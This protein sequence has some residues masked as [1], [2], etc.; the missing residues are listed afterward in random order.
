MEKKSKT[1]RV[2]AGRFRVQR[3]VY[4]TSQKIHMIRIS[5]LRDITKIWKKS[6]ILKMSKVI[7]KLPKKNFSHKWSGDLSF[8]ISNEFIRFSESV[9]IYSVFFKSSKIF[10]KISK[11]E[12]NVTNFEYVVVKKFHITKDNFR[13]IKLTVAQLWL[14]FIVKNRIFMNIKKNWKNSYR[15]WKINKFIWNGQRIR[16]LKTIKKYNYN[17][18]IIKI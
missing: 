11:I 9:R 13:I 18:F 16:Y 5:V 17:I 6:T 3:R 2:T 12:Y 10:L 8:F 15:F 4:P 1:V 7:N 14:Q